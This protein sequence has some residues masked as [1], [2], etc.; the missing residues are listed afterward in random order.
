MSATV[1][2]AARRREPASLLDN[3]TVAA[4]NGIATDS[5]QTHDTLH[6]HGMGALESAPRRNWCGS[7]CRQDFE[8]M[9]GT[10]QLRDV[11]SASGRLQA[12]CS[13]TSHA[14]R[15]TRLPSCSIAGQI[16]EGVTSRRITWPPSRS[17]F[18]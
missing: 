15:R 3:L 4:G 14:Q 9:S 12:P 5:L 13:C 16:N 2:R 10:H 11:V 18:R 7:T 8:A 1:T 6:A 17:C